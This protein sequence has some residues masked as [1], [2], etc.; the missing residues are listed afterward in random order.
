MVGRHDRWSRTASV[1]GVGTL[2]YSILALLATQSRIGYE[3]AQLMKAPIGYMWTAQH[4]QIY[5]EL[6]RLLDQGFVSAMTVTGSGPR[7]TR[8]YTITGAGE[9][10]LREWVN[11][12]LREVSRN[13]L[14]LRVRALWLLDPPR[15]RDF[16]VAQRARQQQLL[17]TYADE[18]DR[19]APELDDIT[20]PTTA[21]FAEW[22]TLRYGIS[23]A[24][25][26]IEWFD[27]I[28]TH[29]TAAV[30]NC[31]TAATASEGRPLSPTGSAVSDASQQSAPPIEEPVPTAHPPR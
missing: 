6:S 12:P 13:E 1:P 31:D 3:I 22:A 24:Q 18:E 4:S 5:P 10:A 28:L 2:G 11:S 17:D 7:D 19:F 25:T 9:A 26:T 16:I 21:S 15:A 23:H 8:R 30:T 29:Y 27:W 20:D 14:L